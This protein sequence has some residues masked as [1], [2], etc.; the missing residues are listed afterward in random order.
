MEAKKTCEINQELVNK[1]LLAICKKLK[2]ITNIS[3]NYMDYMSALIYVFY[4]NNRIINQILARNIKFIIEEIDYELQQIKKEESS[5]RLFNDI[6]FEKVIT[7]E[8]YLIFE[9]AINDLGKLILELENSKASLAE[10]FEYIIMKAEQNNE[11][12]HS[13]GEYYTPKGL[14]KTMVKVLDVKDKMSVYNPF[15]ATGN[16]IVECAKH[17]QIYSFGE[18]TDNSNYNICITNLWLHDIINKRIKENS[19]EEVQPVDIAIANPP[20]KA[21]NGYNGKLNRNYIKETSISYVQYL[22]LIIDSVNM[23][24]K[25]AIV[26]PQG[27]LFK[28]SNAERSMRKELIDKNYIDAIIS[29]PEKLFYNTRIPVIILIINKIRSQKYGILFIDASNE[30]TSKR[31]TNILTVQNQDKIAE[32]YRKY[33]SLKNYSYVANLKEIQKNDYD[34][35]IKK[36]VKSEENKEC[37]SKQEIEENIRY[38][39]KERQEIEQ[40]IKQLMKT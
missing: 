22:K 18:E 7:Q 25:A 36:Y 37:I 21:E 3:F 40:K 27:F 14:I 30:Y 31:K 19:F 35:N 11:V 39:E 8:Y 23:S 28:Q 38:L 26:L 15:C 24:G 6:I 9:D 17:A 20:F 12:S 5:N 29:L 16:F 4:S 10:A 1:K 2:S 34:L 32:T 33:V 13:N